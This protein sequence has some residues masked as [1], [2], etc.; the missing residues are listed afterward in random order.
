MDWNIEWMNDWFV[1][2]GDV[3]WRQSNSGIANVRALAQRVAN[4]IRAIDPDVLTIQEGPSDPREMDLFVTDF[5]SQQN[6]QPMFDIFG[7]L[8]GRSQKVY[9]L[10]KRGGEYQNARLANDPLTA[11]LFVEWLADVNGD[12]HLEPYDYTRD[13]L[14]VDGELQGTGETLRVLSLHTKSKYVNEQED[15]WRD[16]DRR[17]EF[18]VAA[19]TNR[20]RISAEAMHTRIYL[21]DLY[22]AGAGALVIVTG[23]FNDGP[24]IDYFER[25]YLTHGVAD[26]LLGSIYRPYRQYQHTLIGNVPANELYTARFDDF[27]DDIDDRPL[28]LDHVLVSP[29]L[30]NRYAN[31]RIAHAEYDAEEDTARPADDRDRFPSDHRPVVVEI[32]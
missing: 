20:R 8:D 9:A 18:V 17:Q 4:V 11:A 5:L 1:G 32:G 31:A 3:A 7:G 22:D 30:Q 15:L 6:G 29:A 13:P 14:V 25:H 19:L 21:D 26:I 27:I 23:D 28:L 12:A 24:G 2:G 16:L 10:V